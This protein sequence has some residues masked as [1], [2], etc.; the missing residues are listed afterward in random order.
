MTVDNFVTYAGVVTGECEMFKLYELT[1]NSFKCLILILGLTSN[2]DA[3]IRSRILTKVEM[4]SKLTLKK[5]AEECIVN[6]KL[7]T[8]R[9]EERHLTNT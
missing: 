7:D 5:I 4:D 2:K 3:E 8:I 9:I 6:L 1:S